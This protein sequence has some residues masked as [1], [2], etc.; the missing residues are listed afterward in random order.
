M[1]RR[2]SEWLEGKKYDREKRKN[3]GKNNW[4]FFFS[5]RVKGNANNDILTENCNILN[6]T[7]ARN[8]IVLYE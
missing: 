6:H 5:L 1:S 8:E 3:L 7:R 4:N 2:R